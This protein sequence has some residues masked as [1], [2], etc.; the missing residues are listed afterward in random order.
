MIRRLQPVSIAGI[1]FDAMLEEQKSLNATIPKYPVE[2]G[3]PVSD[4]IILE[5]ISLS[6]TL[7]VSNTPV[8]FLYRH[9]KS[10][11]R[12]KKVCEQIE[13]LWLSKKLVKIVTPDAVY[14]DMGI[15]SI[16]IKKSKEIGYAREISISAIKVI[17]T[18]RTTV[19][20]PGHILKSGESMANA[21]TATTSKTS[22]KSSAQITQSESNK[23]SNLSN[24]KVTNEESKS[25]NDSK[26]GQS[27]LYGTA[28]GLGII[29]KK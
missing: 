16:A 10:N 12:V 5:P 22:S 13:Q 19:D 18:N 29:K 11:D 17:T 25:K 4:T 28:K 21:G 20:I 14:T 3:F 9:G 27:I 8:T 23:S 6:F 15:T 26:K 2:S 7:Y 1:T 24:S